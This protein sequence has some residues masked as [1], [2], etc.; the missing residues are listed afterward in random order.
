RFDLAAGVLRADR[1]AGGA[2]PVVLA[3]GG[4][5]D[6]RTARERLA[7]PAERHP[8]MRVAVAQQQLA[9]AVGARAAV[10]IGQLHAFFQRR[11]GT[12]G[13]GQVGRQQGGAE[14]GREVFHGE[15]SCLWGG[16]S[17]G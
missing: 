4:D 6:A 12:G 17:T 14:D 10:R 3:V 2:Q 9:V 15:A 5:V 1:C 13:G 8:V 11:G 7:G 16:T